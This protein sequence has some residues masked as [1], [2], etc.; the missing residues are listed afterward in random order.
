MGDASRGTYRPAIDAVNALGRPV[1]EIIFRLF[2]VCV[3]SE[4]SLFS[5][6]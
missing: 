4:R 1:G 2:S 5:Q 3:R 6:V